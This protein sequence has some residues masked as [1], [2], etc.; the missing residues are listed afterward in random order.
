MYYN[1]FCVNKQK[2]QFEDFWQNDEYK[3]FFNEQLDVINNQT[4]QNQQNQQ[5]QNFAHR[6]INQQQIEINQNMFRD[7]DKYKIYSNYERYQKQNLFGNKIFHDQ[8]NEMQ[9]NDY[10]DISAEKNNIQFRGDK[11]LFKFKINSK[12]LIFKTPFLNKE[13]QFDLLDY[14][15]LDIDDQYQN[16]ILCIYDPGNNQET[17]TVT[18]DYKQQ[19][20]ISENKPLN[21]IKK[22]KLFPIFLIGEFTNEVV[23]EQEKNQHVKNKLDKS[24]IQQKIINLDEQQQKQKKVNLSAYYDWRYSVKN[25]TEDTQFENFQKYHKF[26]ILK[27]LISDLEY[28]NDVFASNAFEDLSKHT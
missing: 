13:K 16:A 17:K 12:Y 28:L 26:I 8:L 27:N 4:Q 6:I 3:L 21:E 2:Q 19:Y 5:K 11:T 23:K 25:Y 22:D 18:Y 10:I 15:I 1:V 20:I 24:N 14:S 9:Y 7:Y